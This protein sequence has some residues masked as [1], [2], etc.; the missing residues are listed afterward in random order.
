MPPD[1]AN[2]RADALT[3]LMPSLLRRARRSSHSRDDAED[4]AQEALLRVWSRLEIIDDIEG[5]DG[6]LM[7]TLRHLSRRRHR[8]ALQCEYSDTETNDA[9]AETRIFTAQ[10]L[11][12]VARLPRQEAEMISAIA[13]DGMSYA[14]YAARAGLPVG[15]VMSRLSRSRRKLRRRLALGRTIAG[16]PDPTRSQI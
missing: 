11:S 8:G 4:L 16:A 6:Y 10:V 9:S 5:I 2:A 3:R 13:L 12:E 15:T 1:I 14:E 7:V